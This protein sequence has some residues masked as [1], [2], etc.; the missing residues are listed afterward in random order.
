MRRACEKRQFSRRSGFTLIELLVVV[1]IIALLIA[2]LVPTLALAKRRANMARCL[3]NLKQ[4]AQA[5]IA[6]EV[7]HQRLPLHVNELAPAG[8]GANPNA[9]AVWNAGVLQDARPLWRQYVNVNFFVCPF[10]PVWQ[11]DTVTLPTTSNSLNVEYI[12]AGGYWGDGVGA[13]F[14]GRWL[15]TK[16][17]WEYD[18]RRFWALVGDRTF[19]DRRGVVATSP[20]GQWRNFINHADIGSG[21]VMNISQ[22]PRPTGRGYYRE[23]SPG[24]DLRNDFT[25]NFAFADGSAD[26]FNRSSNRL[27]DVP[28]RLGNAADVGQVY[29]VP[30]E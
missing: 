6:Y 25:T 29:S 10:V 24:T 30:A 28:Y 4:V 22:A 2:I 19:I 9:V 18:G 27:V 12:F 8:T 23:T 13:S 5:S 14:G 20:A 21:F 17:P 26:T 3:S 7:E 11:P 15:R 1:G 16:E